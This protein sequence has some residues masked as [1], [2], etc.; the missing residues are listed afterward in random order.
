VKFQQFVPSVRKALA[1]GA[2]IAIVPATVALAAGPKSAAGTAKATPA[3]S[4]ARGLATVYPFGDHCQ[5]R[6]PAATLKRDANGGGTWTLAPKVTCDHQKTKMTVLA[7]LHR[8]GSVIL[9][10]AGSCQVGLK[11]LTC[12]SATGS[13]RSIHLGSVA[14]HAHYY[15]IE[16][17]S[18]QGPDAFFW[19]DHNRQAC[20]FDALT[21]TA[22][23]RYQA[24]VQTI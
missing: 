24:E 18:I 20:K 23:C 9:G 10:S 14:V 8:N 4:S 1:V 11:V 13:P 15:V 5:L 16:S 2:V 21:T 17:Y 12:H 7:G 6:N 3:A 19:F 22:S